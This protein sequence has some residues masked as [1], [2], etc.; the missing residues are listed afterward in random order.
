M[1]SGLYFK[2]TTNGKPTTCIPNDKVFVDALTSATTQLTVKGET[3]S[4]LEYTFDEVLPKIMAFSFHV[5][6]PLLLSDLA[7]IQDEC[8]LQYTQDP[9]RQGMAHWPK[10]QKGRHQF[11]VTLVCENHIMDRGTYGT[12]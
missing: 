7:M 8:L 12:L 3:Y 10:G 9:D 5:T 2:L 11:S 1:A 6:S 4:Y